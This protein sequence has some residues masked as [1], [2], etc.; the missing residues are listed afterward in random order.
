MNHLLPNSPLSFILGTPTLKIFAIVSKL[1]QQE[2]SF[3]ILV[4]KTHL[5][6]SCAY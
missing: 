3:E 1:M 4:S 2:A 5:W 6:L